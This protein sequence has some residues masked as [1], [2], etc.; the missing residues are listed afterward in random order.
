M[1]DPGTK[2]AWP[3]SLNPYRII[4]RTDPVRI[5]LPPPPAPGLQGLKDGILE[6]R[7]L[8]PF[9]KGC[10]G[11]VGDDY[12]RLYYRSPFFRRSG[13]P[14]L[15]AQVSYEPGGIVLTGYY[16]MRWSDRLSMS[17][18]FA[19]V[20]VLSVPLIF[21]N[22]VDL[23]WNHQAIDLASLTVPAVMFG[24]GILF[25]LSGQESWEEDKRRIESF[26]ARHAAGSNE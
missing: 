11:E 1:P 3:W 19:V 4:W 20:I 21:T 16:R 7:L 14:V 8:N 6:W 2:V 15:E 24:L 26:I 9:A 12:V 17:V 5:P 18:W 10:G 25:L 13:L 22:L 23:A